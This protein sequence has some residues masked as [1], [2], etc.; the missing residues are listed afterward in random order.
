MVYDPVLKKEYDRLRNLK[1]KEEYMKKNPNYKPVRN[2]QK[3]KRDTIKNGISIKNNSAPQNIG[4]ENI[5]SNASFGLTDYYAN[6]P[7]PKVKEKWNP[8]G[9]MK[10]KDDDEYEDEPITKLPNVRF[11]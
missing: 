2:Q 1:L 6:I 7:K 10:R 5:L 3:E 4:F 11:Y 8:N 9:L